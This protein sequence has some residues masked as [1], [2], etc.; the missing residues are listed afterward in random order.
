MQAAG[1]V[2]AVSQTKPHT[3]CHSG[4]GLCHICLT[5][6][7]IRHFPLTLR[8]DSFSH[9]LEPL[10]ASVSTSEKQWSLL[11]TGILPPDRAKYV[12]RIA[13]NFLAVASLRE[14]IRRFLDGNNRSWETWLLL[15]D[16][17]L[18]E[19]NIFAV[20]CL[21]STVTLSTFPY[22]EIRVVSRLPCY[23]YLELQSV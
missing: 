22:P 23:W 10:T 8:F 6:R 9:A 5:L 14:K 15:Q 1:S 21:D 20:C 3:I 7:Y 12:A 11:K 2:L 18:Y 16:T 19:K 13:L 17:V 4:W